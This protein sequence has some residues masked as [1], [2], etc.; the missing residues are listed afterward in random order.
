MGASERAAVVMA[1]GMLLLPD[2]GF[3]QTGPAAP[4]QERPEAAPAPES[5]SGEVPLLPPAAGPELR[6]MGCE[7]SSEPGTGV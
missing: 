5:P 4:E 6:R 2:V 7:R 1:V 3:G